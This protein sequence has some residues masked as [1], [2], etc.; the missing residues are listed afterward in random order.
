M[1]TKCMTGVVH[2]CGE[3]SESDT[4][5]NEK[6]QT[7]L[8]RSMLKLGKKSFAMERYRTAVDMIYKN[9]GVKVSSEFQNLYWEIVGYGRT[10]EYTID[11]VERE[12]AERSIYSGACLCDFSFFHSMYN[13]E[14]P[15]AVRQGVNSNLVPDYRYFKQG[16]KFKLF[17]LGGKQAFVLTCEK[18]ARKRYNYKAW[19]Q[20]DACTASIHIR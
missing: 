20:S 19:K 18:P 8:I 10:E 2:L 13:L 12:L 5:L 6:L 11:D 4:V 15:K 16:L 3:N 17:Q 9:L 7:V 1:K 14:R